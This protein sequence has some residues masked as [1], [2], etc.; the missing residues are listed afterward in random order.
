MKAFGQ[1][2]AVIFGVI[3][4]RK[5]DVKRAF[6]WSFFIAFMGGVPFYFMDPYDMTNKYYV[7][8]CVFL[9]SFGIVSSFSLIYYLNPLIFPSLFV[10]N[11]FAIANI[12]A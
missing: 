9:S 7:M 3:V 6:I 4:E 11:S 8:G 2:L 5:F 1:G 10:G 12:F